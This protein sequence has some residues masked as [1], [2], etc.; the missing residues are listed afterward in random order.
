MLLAGSC[1]QVSSK[2]TLCSLWKLSRLTE[3]GFTMKP[4][5]LPN[6]T[7]FPAS[8]NSPTEVKG[9]DMS[10]I[11]NVWPSCVEPSSETISKVFWPKFVMSGQVIPFKIP[12][13]LS[14]TRWIVHYT[15][16]GLPSE[17][18]RSLD[19]VDARF[20]RQQ[21]P[22]KVKTPRAVRLIDLVWYWTELNEVF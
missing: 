13:A 2:Y 9:L 19:L 17:T 5:F 20:R 21:I 12:R 1:D 3:S 11:W 7:R 10:A 8:A 6:T 18:W 16:H 15:C 4:P 22:K 14:P